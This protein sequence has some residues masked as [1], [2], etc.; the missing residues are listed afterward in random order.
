MLRRTRGG[1]F[2]VLKAARHFPGSWKVDKR[3]LL[4]YS[5]LFMQGR[6]PQVANTGLVEFS[7]MSNGS[8]GHGYCPSR[9]WIIR[10]FLPI[11]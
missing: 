5:A 3:G 8:T 11:A 4:S 9:W 10:T 1:L 2:L 6:T 7:T